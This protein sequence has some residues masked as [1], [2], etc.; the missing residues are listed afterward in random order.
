MGGGTFTSLL[1][2]HYTWLDDEAGE[3]PE[4]ASSFLSESRYSRQRG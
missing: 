3:E 1:G 4:R 2:P